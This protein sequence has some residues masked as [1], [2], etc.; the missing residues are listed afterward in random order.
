CKTYDRYSGFIQHVSQYFPSQPQTGFSNQ[1]QIF[2]P[3]LNNRLTGVSRPKNR[4]PPKD[5]PLSAIVTAM[6]SQIAAAWS[7]GSFTAP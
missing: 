4:L 5:R 3:S 6:I 1:K 2:S 7:S